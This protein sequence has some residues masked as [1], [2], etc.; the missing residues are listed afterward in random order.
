MIL[1]AL[2]KRYEDSGGALPGWQERPADYAVNIDSDGNVL[3]IIPL[4]QMDGKKKIRRMLCLPEEPQGRTSGIKPSFLC[5]NAGYIFGMDTKRGEKKFSASKDL[6]LTVLENVD[7]NVAI[8]IK[9]Y[10][11]KPPAVREDLDPQRNNCVFMVNGIYANEDAD[12]ASAWDEYREKTVSGETARCLVSGE[13]DHIAELHGKISLPGVSMGAVPLISINS[14]SFASYGKNASE[15][16]AQIGEAAAFAYTTALNGLLASGNHH[17]RFGSDTIVY[18][19]EG[20]G[21]TEAEV[22][23]LMMVPE[24]SDAEKLEGIMSAIVQGKDVRDIDF[25]RPFSLLGLS[26]NA[27]R[28]S[29]RFFYTDMFGNVINNIMEHYD[30]L[31]IVAPKND[32]FPHLPPWILLSETTVS[33]KIRD[34]APLLSG[35]LLNSII[36]GKPYPA[37]LYNSILIRVRANEQISKT[38]AAIIKAVLMRKLKK[39][40]EVLTVS[41]NPDSDNKPYVLGR[42]FATLEELQ[43]RSAEGSLNATIRDRYFGSACANPRSV[44]PTLL[45]LSMH[46]AAKPKYIPKPETLKGELLDKL[47]IDNAPFPATLSLDDQGIFILGYYHQKM[48]GFYDNGDQMNEEDEANV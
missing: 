4:E 6:H 15:P 35:Q 47:D 16:A 42:L 48:H 7:N 5:D 45:K 23:S 25:K 26:P 36:T 22:F 13:I 29:V 43:R 24:E 1:Q 2:V 9:N 46:H 8:A 18:W 20:E 19:A 33:K 30:N 34:V 32:R 3:D 11:K 27:G 10:F 39:E 28:M 17:K 41:L 21:D 38:K 31:K 40:R 37:S 44:F 12:I 14:E